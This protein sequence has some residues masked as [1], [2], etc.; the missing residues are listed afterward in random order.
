MNV[1]HRIKNLY[2]AVNQAIRS[3][4]Q[5]ESRNLSSNSGA[6]SRPGSQKVDLESYIKMGVLHAGGTLSDVAAN[7]F[8]QGSIRPSASA[9]SQAKRKTPL[10]IAEN[11]FRKTNSLYIKQYT[12]HKRDNPI[13]KGYIPILIDGSNEPIP[14]DI[15]EPEYLIL[16]KNTAIIIRAGIH[17]NAA[18]DALNRKYLRIV[19]QDQK[20]K[21]EREAAKEII[22]WFKKT[23][24]D[25][26][27][28]FIMDRGYFSYSLSALCNTYG[29]KYVIRMKDRDYEALALQSIDVPADQQVDRILTW[30]LRKEEREDPQMK[31]LAK[32][33][34]QEIESSAEWV[35]FSARLVSFKIG[36]AS[37]EGLITNLS[38]DEFSATALK[39]LYHGRWK[40]ESSFSWL[41]Y[42]V[43]AKR[44]L[45]RKAEYIKQEILF[46]M[47]FYNLCSEIDLMI[48]DSEAKGTCIEDTKNTDTVELKSA[49]ENK[50][51]G[52][53]Y[54]YQP[55]FTKAIRS[56]RKFLV[57][58]WHSNGT[59]KQISIRRIQD[60]VEEISREKLPIR[61]GRS[62]PRNMHPNRLIPFQYR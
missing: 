47:V 60:L 56:I 36:P 13:L 57:G 17:I 49:C 30:H 50:E 23:Y 12:D 11:V 10:Y 54:E 8:G 35:G 2:K 44:I 45:S 5:E 28:I 52:T 15:S 20:N 41:K 37:Y 43:G 26:K 48:E 55:N 4:A 16:K 39:L 62:F 21:D 14:P 46:S 24:P 53:R 42:G 61:P 31:Y 29:Y 3:V 22:E 19:F 38:S 27:F 33:S 9:L 51:K 6:Y 1:V 58:Q 7:Y 59:R 18:Y 34:L 32:R 40:I 25:E